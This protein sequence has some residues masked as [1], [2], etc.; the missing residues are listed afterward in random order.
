MLDNIQYMVNLTL[1]KKNPQ[2]VDQ[3][4]NPNNVLKEKTTFL[5]LI[6]IFH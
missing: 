3:K 5:A 2:R 6:Y 4:E 1:E